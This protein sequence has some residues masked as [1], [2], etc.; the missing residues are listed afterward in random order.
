M[1]QNFVKVWRIKWEFQ[2]VEAE[3]SAI[4]FTVHAVI[5]VSTSRGLNSANGWIELSFFNF[6][7]ETTQEESDY[8][9]RSPKV[10][11]AVMSVK[12]IK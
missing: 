11:V 5:V 4:K 1:D 12:V 9:V 10:I 6:E 7:V 2:L 3:L 8:S